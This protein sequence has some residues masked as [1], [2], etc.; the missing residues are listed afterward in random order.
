MDDLARPLLEFIKTYQDWAIAIILITAFGESLA[1]VSLLFPGTMLLIAAGTLM[2]AGVLPYFPLIA[3]AIIG[4]VLGDF[5]S[6]W[7][8][9]G[10]GDRVA[11]VWPL[12]RN[13]E[14]LPVGI[15]FFER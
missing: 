12:S 11:G 7:I 6:Y 9:R 15:Q 3:A 14:L 8:G 10:L 13:P 2:Q 1:F 4:A 5:V